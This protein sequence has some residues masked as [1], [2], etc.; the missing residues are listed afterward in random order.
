MRRGKG[1][2]VKKEKIKWYKKKECVMLNEVRERA[3]VEER[4][5]GER[6]LEKKGRKVM[7]RALTEGN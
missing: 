4:K 5:T 1:K 3:S 6:A 7:Q 2:M